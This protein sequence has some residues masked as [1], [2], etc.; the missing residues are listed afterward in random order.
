MD[1]SRCFSLA[2]AP[3]DFDAY[4]KVTT[5]ESI[6]VD[7][8]KFNLKGAVNSIMTNFRDCGDAIT[9]S[10]IRGTMVKN[11]VFIGRIRIYFN[12]A[13]K[14]QMIL[15]VDFD[16]NGKSIYEVFRSSNY[17]RAVRTLHNI[18]DYDKFNRFNKYGVSIIPILELGLTGAGKTAAENTTHNGILQYFVI[19][20]D[21]QMIPNLGP[22]Y[23]IIIDG[24]H[25]VYTR[26]TENY[27][28]DYC[29]FDMKKYRNDFIKNME[30]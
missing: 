25:I 16:E 22:L 4:L 3:E 9:V 6:D 23:N 27:D 28:R 13:S 24:K 26:Y 10:V 2:E 7:T 8:V 21:G 19:G 12:S 17:E 11:K 18:K 30:G 1:D 5:G 20:M 29:K 15:S 14:G